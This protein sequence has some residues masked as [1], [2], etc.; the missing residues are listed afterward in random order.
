MLKHVNLF[1][2]YTTFKRSPNSH[3]TK[4]RNYC[5]WYGE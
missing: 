5:K 2:N 4:Y 1:I 3:H